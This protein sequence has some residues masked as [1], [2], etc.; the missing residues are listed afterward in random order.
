MLVGYP[1]CRNKEFLA[2]CV[3]FTDDVIRNMF[4]I[5]LTPRVL[6]PIGG[7]LAALPN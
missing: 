3:Y 7:E 1:L 2:N 5:G 6:R 4:L